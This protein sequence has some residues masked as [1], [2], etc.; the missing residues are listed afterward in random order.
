MEKK[1]SPYV[2]IKIEVFESNAKGRRVKDG[3]GSALVTR[4]VLKKQAPAE[5][6]R[7]LQDALRWARVG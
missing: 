7:I 1:E 5:A 2:C 4:G 3:N 6:E